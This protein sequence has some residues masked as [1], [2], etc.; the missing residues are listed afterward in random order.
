MKLLFI[1]IYLSFL[2]PLEY[3]IIYEDN[4]YDSANSIANLYSNEVDD[5]FKLDTETFSKSYIE[6]FNGETT[7]DKIK[8]FILELKIN[9]PELD[10]IL[11]LGD[12]NSFP[13]IYNKS[14]I[15][16]DDFF[17][18]SNSINAPPTISIGRVPSSDINKVNTFVDKLTEFLLSP[19]IGEWRDKAILIAD[20]E[21][22]SGE[23]EAC[24]INHTKNS[25]IIYDI[26]GENDVI[27]CHDDIVMTS[28][29][30]GYDLQF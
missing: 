10:Y 5:N 23:N 8:N 11:I 14:E 4:L 12:E 22:K 16:S 15:P 18:T 30:P 25:D 9:Y 2:F 1:Y 29:C 26:L 20:D 13:P 6:T 7:A 3:A 28:C 27:R 19:T 24:E 21:N 17:T